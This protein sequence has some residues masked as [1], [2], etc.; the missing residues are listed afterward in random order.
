[1][2]IDFQDA[3]IINHLDSKALNF[4]RLGIYLLFCHT[5]IIDFPNIDQFPPGASDSDVTIT[6]N[7]NAATPNDTIEISPYESTISFDANKIIYRPYKVVEKSTLDSFE[8]EIKSI[9]AIHLSDETG[10]I[11]LSGQCFDIAGYYYEL[12][13]AIVDFTNT[14]DANCLNTVDLFGS[15]ISNKAYEFIGYWTAIMANRK[16]KSDAAFKR[17]S[18]ME[19]AKDKEKLKVLFFEKHGGRLSMAYRRDAQGIIGKT[20]RT[21]INLTKEIEKENS[22]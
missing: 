17:P 20:E 16:K 14:I 5:H 6:T 22:E 10:F 18:S 2:T 7:A 21:V 15:Y 12:Y 13:T 4:E 3:K 11:K 1:M 9:E 8:N 19:K